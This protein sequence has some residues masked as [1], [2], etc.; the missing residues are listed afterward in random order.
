MTNTTKSVDIVAALSECAS[1]A[2]AC[3]K[4]EIS[5]TRDKMVFADGNPLARVMIVGEGPGETEDRTG[6]PY[7]GPAGDLLDKMLAS[8]GLDRTTVYIANIIKCR[9]SEYAGYVKNRPPTRDEAANCSEYLLEQIRLVSPDVILATGAPAAKAL[10]GDPNFA[11][12]RQRGKWYQGPYGI[13]TLVTFHPAY[14]LRLRGD[15]LQKAKM[16]VWT[17]LKALR[18][19]LN[20][21]DIELVGGR[22]DCTEAHHRATPAQASRTIGK[23]LQPQ[24]FS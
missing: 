8:I 7:V 15:E 1:R 5:K 14:I 2:N 24:L 12:T 11:I 9:A 17:D 23:T 21:N 20:G 13:T 22:P 16:L 3:T 18:A 10:I 19:R 6:I 4:C